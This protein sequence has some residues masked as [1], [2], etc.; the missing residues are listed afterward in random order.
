LH[1]PWPARR[2][3]PRLTLLRRGFSQPTLRAAF[4]TNATDLFVDVGGITRGAGRAKAPDPGP[5]GG[6]S[7]PAVRLRPS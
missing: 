1:A 5:L 6:A 4:S 7:W 2:D 3:T